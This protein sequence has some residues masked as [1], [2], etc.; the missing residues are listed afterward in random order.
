MHAS[1][2]GVVPLL[3]GIAVS[4]QSAAMVHQDDAQGLPFTRLAAARCVPRFGR[5]SIGA[6]AAGNLGGS[7]TRERRQPSV[8]AGLPLRQIDLRV[9]FGE[10]AC[11]GNP[12]SRDRAC[13]GRIA[14]PLAK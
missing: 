14:D 9:V 13:R 12:G 3:P 1:A 5:A 7:P 6:T 8:A 4:S 11:E 2:G 10:A